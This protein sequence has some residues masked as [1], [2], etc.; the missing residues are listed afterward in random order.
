M[1]RFPWNKCVQPGATLL[2]MS[3]WEKEYATANHLG[4]VDF[5]S[6]LVG[7]EG[8]FKPGLSVDGVHPT[9]RGYELMTPVAED[10][11]EKVLKKR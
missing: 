11:I 4:Y 8:T 10:V 2:A 9:K 7:E 3:A 1:T 5:Y 6:A